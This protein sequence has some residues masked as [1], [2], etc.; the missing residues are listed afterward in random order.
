[1]KQIRSI[2]PALAWLGL[3]WL[4][5]S[6]PSD[7]IPS[8]KVIGFDKLAHVT[9]YAILG[10]LL[11]PWLK[12]KGYKKHQ[13]VFIY[14]LMLLL[15]AADEYHQNFIPGRSVAVWD[16]MANSLGLMIGFAIKLRKA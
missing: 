16:L 8:V 3:I 12:H 7:N 1:M 2:Y 4:L 13:V 10:L 14:A 6:L 9:V 5:S 15:A 11:N